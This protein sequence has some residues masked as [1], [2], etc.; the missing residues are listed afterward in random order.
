MATQCAL[1]IKLPCLA[2]PL[3]RRSLATGH[4]RCHRPP[5]AILSLLKP[6]MLEGRCAHA[7][8]VTGPPLPPT[9]TLTLTHSG[10]NF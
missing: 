4:I 1:Q 7:N 10:P 9:P 8:T 3:D 2:L 5:E 6:R